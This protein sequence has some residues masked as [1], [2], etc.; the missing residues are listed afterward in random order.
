MAFTWRLIILYQSATYGVSND[1][2]VIVGLP[3]PRKRLRAII[4]RSLERSLVNCVLDV[5]LAPIYC[6][7][8]VITLL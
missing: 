7:R 5:S 8:A 3:P 1:N 4:C 2:H 6:D